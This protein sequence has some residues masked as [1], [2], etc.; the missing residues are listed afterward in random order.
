ME[1]QMDAGNLSHGSAV[2]NERSAFQSKF[3]IKGTIGEVGKIDI[4]A[5]ICLLKQDGGRARERLL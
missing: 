4:L 2:A 3:R 5:N 1:R